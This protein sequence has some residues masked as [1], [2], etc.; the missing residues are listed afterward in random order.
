MDIKNG[1]TLVELSIVLVIIGLIIGGILVGQDL[2][3][4]AQIRAQVSQME[5]LNT[6]VHTFKLKYDGI[7]GALLSTD[8]KAFGLF[9]STNGTAR[10]WGDGNGILESGNAGCNGAGL[11][12]CFYAELLIFWRHLSDANLIDGTYAP[13][14]LI[15]NTG[16]MNGVSYAINSFIPPAKI[17]NGASIAVNPYNGINYFTLAGFQ[18]FTTN[19]GYY[20]TP[21]T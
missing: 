5:K 12:N 1:F 13:N 11:T 21:R 17:G 15:D 4:S 20:I 10:P 9:A 19:N 16:V 2:I 8:A 18:N 6:S 7:P 14:N 3:H